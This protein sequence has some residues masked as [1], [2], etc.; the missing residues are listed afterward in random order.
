MDTCHLRLGEDIKMEL[1]HEGK[2]ILIEGRLGEEAVSR[3]RRNDRADMGTESYSG[4]T[5]WKHES[6]EHAVYDVKV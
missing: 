3:E 2:M 4:R 1:K 5:L 6:Y